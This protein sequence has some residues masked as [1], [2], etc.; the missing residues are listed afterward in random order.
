LEL[1]CVF[2]VDEVDVSER[3]QVWQV[4]NI[5]AGQRHLRQLRQRRHSREGIGEIERG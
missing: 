4:A 1:V 3:A 2:D 5:F